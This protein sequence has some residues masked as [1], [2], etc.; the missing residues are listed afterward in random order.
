MASEAVHRDPVWRQRSNFIIFAEI[1]N[2]GDTKTEQL[3]ARQI[4]SDRFEICC[5]PF[6]L[7]DLSLGDV[8]G[9]D[10]DYMV[11]RVIERSGRYVFRV[12]FGESSG[13]SD[14]ILEE[15]K[16]LGA[17]TEWSSPN[18]LAID[19]MDQEQAKVIA[20]YLARREREKR[21]MYET[22]RR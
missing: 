16:A 1:P 6:F 18:L 10:D 8:V 14:E 19:A 17:L 20:S 22:G 5:I 7:Y 2:N 12:W 21:L 11:R 13:S 4:G 3:W 9:T 15:I